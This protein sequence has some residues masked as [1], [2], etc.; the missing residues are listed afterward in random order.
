MSPITTH[1]LDT[2]AGTPGR[3]I[4][5]ILEKQ[6]GENFVEISRGK[7]NDDGRLPGLLKEGELEKA[8]YQIH[9]LTADYYKSQGKKCFYPKVS[10]L[11]TIEESIEH[12]H[13]PLLISGFGYSTYRGS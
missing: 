13:I 4:E 3:G 12:Y 1:V 11:F 9:F 2:S 8:T 10:V 5:I 6:E 7:T